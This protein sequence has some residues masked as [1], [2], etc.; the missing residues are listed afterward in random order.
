MFFEALGEFSIFLFKVLFTPFRLKHFFR[1]FFTYIIQS[2]PLIVMASLSVGAVLALEGYISLKPFGA[3]DYISAGVALS[4]FRELSPVMVNFLLAARSTSSLASKIATLKVTERLEAL[5]MLAINPI[6]F[7][8]TPAMYAFI[9]G[10]ILLT[11]IG[12]AFGILGSI[13]TCKYAFSLNSKAQYSYIYTIIEYR[14]LL[15]GLIKS[16]FF[17]IFTC[18]FA[19]YFGFKA[20]L[21]SEG[22][23]KATTRAV[24]YSS[25]FILISDYFLTNILHSLKI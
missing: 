15:H 20:D 8:A 22:V 24:T 5:E 23:G 7:L 21:G 16:F 6:S 14:D 4:L 9:F 12:D 13:L 18:A 2:T 3:T 17:G 11:L 10:S 19:C 25:I 1:D